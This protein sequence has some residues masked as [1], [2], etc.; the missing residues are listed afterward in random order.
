MVQS[1]DHTTTVS[2]LDMEMMTNLPIIT[3]ADDIV[4]PDI[5]KETAIRTEPA[6]DL[7]DISKFMTYPPPVPNS[8]ASPSIID[9]TAS[10]TATTTS[11]RLKVSNKTEAVAV[12]SADSDG[13]YDQYEDFSFDS[14]LNMLFGS[15]P[16]SKIANNKANVNETVTTRPDVTTT[17]KIIS[18]YE[19]NVLFGVSAKEEHPKT[20]SPVFN[21]YDFDADIIRNTHDF[22][23]QIALPSDNRPSNVTRYPSRQ[24]NTAENKH[25]FSDSTS[26]NT[27]S[28]VITGSDPI[29]SLGLLKLDGCNIYGKMYG[30]GI[31]IT[32]LSEPC[33]ECRCTQVGVQCQTVNC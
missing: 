22:T 30:V 10:T 13:D 31:M 8:T 16:D 18:S 2:P 20:Q 17:D 4:T 11:H 24:T 12:P 26:S 32:E 25:N 27:K 14:V 28:K 29:A 21:S 15:G 1:R 19:S 7:S 23:D 33:L 5:I 6:P 9:L 3:V